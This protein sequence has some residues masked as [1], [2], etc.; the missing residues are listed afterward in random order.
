MA[1][2]FPTVAAEGLLL[3]PPQGCPHKT[4]EAPT[5]SKA[6]LFDSYYCYYF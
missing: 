4:Q 6:L 3:A 1:A 2:P 5:M